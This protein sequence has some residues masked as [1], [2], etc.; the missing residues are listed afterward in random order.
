MTQTNFVPYQKEMQI[1]M[2]SINKGKVYVML[3]STLAL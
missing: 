2:V 1:K 3:Q